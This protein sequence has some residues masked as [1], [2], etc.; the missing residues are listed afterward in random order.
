MKP[1]CKPK[2][3]MNGCY[4]NSALLEDSSQLLRRT[5]VVSTLAS[6]LMGAPDEKSFY[7]IVSWLLVPLFRADG[8]SYLF[9]KDTEHVIVKQVM[10]NKRE[11]AVELGMDN[12]FSGVVKPINGTAVGICA[13][14]LQHYTPNIK[15]SPFK[16]QRAIH[17]MGLNSILVTPILGDGNKFVGCINIWMVKVDA[18]KEYDRILIS[19]IGKKEHIWES[20]TLIAVRFFNPI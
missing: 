19:D 1:W 7:D 20:M 2:N 11:H 16:S 5:R 6:R 17:S 15:D 3:L 8:C 14:T 18:F 4:P 9:L 10:V 13:K 12:I